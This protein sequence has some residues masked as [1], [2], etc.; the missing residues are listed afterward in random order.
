MSAGWAMRPQRSFAH[1]APGGH[2]RDDHHGHGMIRFRSPIVVYNF[3]SPFQPY[4]PYSAFNPY[5]DNYYNDPYA[6]AGAYAPVA[7]YYVPAPDY[8]GEDPYP[9]ANPVDLPIGNAEDP[10][11]TEEADKPAVGI[12]SFDRQGEDAFHARDYKAASRDW[13]HAVVDDPNNSA[14]AVKLGLA[15]FATGE[16]GEAA[17][18]IQ[19]ILMLLPQEQWEQVFS[20]YIKLYS[21][22]KEYLD[23]LKSLERAVAEK[24]K[25]PAL[26]FLLGFHYGFSGRVADAV[27]ELNKL[28]ALVPRDPLGRKLRDL[29][30]EKNHKDN[31]PVLAMARDNIYVRKDSKGVLYFSNVPTDFSYRPLTR[32]RSPGSP[33]L[34]PPISETQDEY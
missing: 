30:A 2:G 13:Q 25:D 20:N 11:P 19:Q 28:V 8:S 7:P 32:E 9:V 1:V 16:Y 34:A 31:V 27:R 33:A 14:L 29:M 6:C 4:Y 23:Q 21:D 17:S 5:C 12:G 18:T 22:P 26:R 10:P 3:I 15:L 24:P